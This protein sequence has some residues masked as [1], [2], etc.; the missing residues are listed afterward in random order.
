MDAGWYVNETGWPNTGTWEVDTKRFPNGLRAI[1]DYAH[2]RGLKCIVW[3]E[4]ERVTPGT[5]LYQNHPEWLIGK[6]D[7]QK[8]LNLGDKAAWDWLVEHIGGLIESQGIDLYR[9]DFNMD[10]LEYWRSAD[11]EDRQGIT[12]NHYVTGYL[13]YWDALRERF[14]NMLIDSCASGGHRND[15][16]TLRR[17][18]PLLRSDYIF[19]PNGQQGHSYGLAPWFPYYGTGVRDTNAY[20][21]RSCM[22]PGMI[23]CWDMRD[24]TLP[25]DEI[26]RLTGQWKQVA[27]NF[28]GDF[29]PL[30]SY[31]IDPAEW[32]A[33]QFHREDAGQG[34]V[35]A[36]R[37]DES[38][39]ESAR[40]RLQG[41]APDATYD[42]TDLDKPEATVQITGRELMEKGLLVQLPDRPAA[43]L[44]AY[45]KKS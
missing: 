30:T 40:F 29:Y 36:F 11:T 21:F 34:M 5:W 20:G 2:A 39:Y 44:I 16:E 4:P 45:K 3:F 42:V 41:L 23:P 37:R 35:Q 14:P 9:Q 31:S 15:I 19:E 26:R 32:I 13:A 10:P 28:F 22:C 8:L 24:R 7:G 6:G 38:V 18:V 12:E 25:Y 27:D 33:W 17:S 43:A 1:T